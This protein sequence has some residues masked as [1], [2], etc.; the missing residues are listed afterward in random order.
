MTGASTTL[1]MGISDLSTSVAGYYYDG[2][3]GDSAAFVESGGIY[4]TPNVPGAAYTIARGVNDTNT[5]VGT[6]VDY[7]YNQVGDSSV[8]YHGFVATLGFATAV[9]EPTTIVSAGLAILIGISV[10]RYR[11]KDA[12]V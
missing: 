10:T 9:P 3:N 1:P 11:R 6:Y 7:H 2:T 4:T 5:V 12:K 8:Y